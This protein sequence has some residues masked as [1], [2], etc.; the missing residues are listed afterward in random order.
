MLGFR[1]DCGTP[2]KR[3]VMSTP[4]GCVLLADEAGLGRPVP[5][6]ELAFDEVE[7]GRPPTSAMPPARNGPETPARECRCS[8]KLGVLVDRCMRSAP[9]TPTVP[10]RAPPNA[11]ASCRPLPEFTPAAIALRAL[12][13]TGGG[14]YFA[15]F[16]ALRLW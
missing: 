2:A 13:D 1:V 3:R 6:R 4:P 15:D 11:G 9:S 7:G 5:S 14:T 16:T 8:G 10:S 12:G